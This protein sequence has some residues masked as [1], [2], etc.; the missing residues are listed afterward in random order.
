MS[1]EL[2]RL[3]EELEK[4]RRIYELTIILRAF[5]M[6]GKL[7]R[8]EEELQNTR[9]ICDELREENER[10]EKTIQ[11]LTAELKASSRK[12][13]YD[14]VIGDGGAKIY[15]WEKNPEVLKKRRED[16]LERHRI[17]Y[18]NRFGAA[19]QD[20][21]CQSDEGYDEID[22]TRLERG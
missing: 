9:R 18:E 11:K 21:S 17:E 15:R 3:G 14:A 2:D 10:K 20:E 6:S 13:V 4:T 7:D 19:N 8:L 5:T 1:E 22:S 16:A 12:Y